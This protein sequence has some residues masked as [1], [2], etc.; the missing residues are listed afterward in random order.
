MSDATTASMEHAVADNSPPQT[1]FR[2]HLKGYSKFIAVFKWGAI[3][4]FV[5]TMI[6]V[7][8]IAS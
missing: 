4:A 7:Y 1:D 6:I 8:V 2:S 5:I 3:V